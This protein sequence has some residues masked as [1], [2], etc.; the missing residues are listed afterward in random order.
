MFFNFLVSQLMITIYN[1]FKVFAN[2]PNFFCKKN[3]TVVKSFFIKLRLRSLPRLTCCLLPFTICECTFPLARSRLL[4]CFC[5]SASLCCLLL[6]W[7]SNTLFGCSNKFTVFV[8]QYS[9]EPSFWHT[10]QNQTLFETEYIAK[11][12]RCSH[13]ACISWSLR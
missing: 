9:P 13:L 7:V 3:K 6:A 10:E 2:Y 12:Y 5:S 8:H 4:N 1:F 11:S